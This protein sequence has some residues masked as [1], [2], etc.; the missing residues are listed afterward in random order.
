MNNQNKRLLSDSII[1]IPLF[2]YN[3]ISTIH[4]NYEKTLVNLSFRPQCPAS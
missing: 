3:F 2:C 4:K 1:H